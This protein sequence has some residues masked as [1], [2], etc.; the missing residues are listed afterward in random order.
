MNPRN[1]SFISTFLLV[2]FSCTP[3]FPGSLDRTWSAISE[4]RMSVVLLFIAC[5]AALCAFFIF[6][7]VR[8]RRRILNYMQQAMARD[9]HDEIGASI[10]NIC[11]LSALVERDLSPAG[12]EQGKEFLNRISEEANKI[13]DTISDTIKVLDPA[14]KRLMGLSALLGHHAQEV[15]RYQPIDFSIHLSEGAKDQRIRACY[16]R[17]FFLILKECL[18]NISRHAKATEVRIEFEEKGGMLYCQI[19]DNGCG[20]DSTV[21]GCCNG[22]KIMA[23]RAKFIGARL[24]IDTWPGRGTEVHLCLPLRMHL[25]SFSYWKHWIMRTK[26][27]MN[28]GGAHLPSKNVLPE[29]TFNSI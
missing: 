12:A 18:H 17:D 27:R 2:I 7:L 11:M 4:G 8:Q 20:F 13:H 22:L 6:L 1:L 3:L 9:M 23:R 19:S 25:L 21:P 26:A 29:I 24:S 14:Y 5:L 28:F 16:R 15:F 10:S